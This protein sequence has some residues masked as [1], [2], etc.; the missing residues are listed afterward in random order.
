VI[1]PIAAITASPTNGWRGALSNFTYRLFAYAGLRKQAAI[2]DSNHSRHSSSP[3]AA[4][5]LKTV[6][7]TIVCVFGVPPSGGLRR[8]QWSA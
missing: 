6:T 5:S 3:C 2:A 8:A 4:C 7:Q 1:I